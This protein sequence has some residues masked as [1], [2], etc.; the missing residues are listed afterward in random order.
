MKE[1]HDEIL[2]CTTKTPWQWCYWELSNTVNDVQDLDLSYDSDV[3]DVV[4]VQ[5]SEF[6]AKKYQVAQG[7]TTNSTHDVDVS[8]ARMSDTTCGIRISSATPEK[9]QGVWKCHLAHTDVLDLNQGVRDEAIFDVNVA[10]PA[11]NLEVDLGSNVDFR[12]GLLVGDEI[13][14]TCRYS[15]G[16]EANPKPTLRIYA[17]DLDQ[18]DEGMSIGNL[19]AENAISR[20]SREVAAESA[21][22]ICWGRTG[23]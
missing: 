6:R 23:R 19:I 10:V 12:S 5:T 18:F 11:K 9:F 20:L 14:I 4:E 8:F 15:N 22:R 3:G 1:G 21:G 7:A 13:N 2:S 17:E 16:I